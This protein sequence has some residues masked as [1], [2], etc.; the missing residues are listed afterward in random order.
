MNGSC[1]IILLILY[2]M[3]SCCG[4]S[5]CEN[6]KSCGCGN[7]NSGLIQPRREQQEASC[8]DC[9]R[10]EQKDSEPC[11]ESVRPFVSYPNSNAGCGCGKN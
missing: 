3:R 9:G 8:D 1:F 7:G 2:A 11:F 10:K 4:E 6:G 5:A